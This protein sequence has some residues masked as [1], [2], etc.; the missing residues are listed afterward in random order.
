[1]LPPDLAFAFLI[2]RT[3]TAYTANAPAYI[4]YTELTHVSAPTLGRTQ[5]INRSVAVRVADNYAVMKDLPN[6]GERT[7]QAFPIIPYFDPMAQF[8]F[9]WFANLKNVQITLNRKTPFMLPIPSAD[10]GIDIVVPYFTQ[11]MPRY[12]PDSTETRP[13]LVIQPVPGTN[14]LYVDDIVIDEQTK[15]PSHIELRSTGDDETI[16]FD[17]KVLEGHWVITHGVFTAT[18]HVAV[19]TFKVISDTQY[20]DI[21]F[22]AGPPDPRL[23]TSPSPAPR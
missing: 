19:M 3:A 12:A 2:N 15:L 6:G 17:Y 4:T 5:D 7:G 16:A 21:A 22:P 18:Q 8:D 13:H 20:N 1:M 23:A 14:G 11:F 10:P 9:S